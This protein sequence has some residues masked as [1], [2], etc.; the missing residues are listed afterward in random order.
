MHAKKFLVRYS[1]VSRT[2]A[3]KLQISGRSDLNRQRDA[4][5][6]GR[7][8]T[9]VSHSRKAAPKS[10]SCYLHRMQLAGR[11]KRG[12]ELPSEVTISRLAR[13]RGDAL[14]SSSSHLHRPYMHLK[15]WS[16]VRSAYRATECCAPPAR[17]YIERIIQ[18]W[19]APP[20]LQASRLTAFF[21]ASPS[22]TGASVG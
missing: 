21:D 16:R 22:A 14:V 3:C 4:R 15:Y 7:Q 20:L 8:S 10:I 13:V 5:E 11:V 12:P 9:S 17:V 19:L 1:R 6:Q 18:S 2:V